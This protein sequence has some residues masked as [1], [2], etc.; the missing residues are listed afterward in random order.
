M[1]SDY[2]PTDYRDYR[3]QTH[4]PCWHT[5]DVWVP[6]IR[7]VFRWHAAHARLTVLTT[8]LKAVIGGF[9]G[10]QPHGRHAHSVIYP[11]ALSVDRALS[12]DKRLASVVRGFHLGLNQASLH[13][14][15]C[16]LGTSRL[17]AHAILN[18]FA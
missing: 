14:H 9:V 11:D 15:N 17:R 16:G 2:H 10:H 3:S 8:D 4:L 18:D 12:E 5:L 13:G 1:Y 6:C 7:T